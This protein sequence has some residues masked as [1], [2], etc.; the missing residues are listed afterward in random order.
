MCLCHP[1]AG[2]TL[3]VPSARHLLARPK[4]AKFKLPERLEVVDSF[5]LSSVGKISKKDLRD[6]IAR[7]LQAEAAAAA[8]AGDRA[9]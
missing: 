8:T 7:K 1:A 3:D 4:I 9:Q 2:R 6:D 5:P